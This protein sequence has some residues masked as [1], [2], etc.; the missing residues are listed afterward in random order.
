MPAH[1]AERI[2][3]SSDGWLHRPASRSLGE[4]H[5]GNESGAGVGSAQFF[6]PSTNLNQL[7]RF[8][9]LQRDGCG[10]GSRAGHCAKRYSHSGHAAPGL[11]WYGAQTSN[12]CIRRSTRSWW[13]TRMRRLFLLNR[14][15]LLRCASATLSQPSG[16]W[17]Q[18]RPMVVTMTTF[19]SPT[20]GARVLAAQLRGDGSAARTAFTNARKSLKKQCVTS[21]TMRQLSVRSVWL[22][23]HW[24]TKRCHSRRRA[25]GRAHPRW[26]KRH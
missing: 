21:P 16:Q 20:V 3:N 19:H 15:I 6:H 7:R 26:Q 25:S 5:R 13:R 9:A 10:F 23:R 1:A 2:P 12:R 17:P 8:A 14:W 4:I 22:M 18:C 11:T 24:E